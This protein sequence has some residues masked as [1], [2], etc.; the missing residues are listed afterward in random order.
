LSYLFFR[1]IIDDG[2]DNKM[3]YELQRKIMNYEL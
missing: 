2:D 1:K 3:S